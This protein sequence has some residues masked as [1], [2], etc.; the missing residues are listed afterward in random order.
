MNH[1]VRILVLFVCLSLGTYCA[2]INANDTSALRT[3]PIIG[4][5]ESIK[6]VEVPVLSIAPIT[7]AQ[8]SQR[9]QSAQIY[10]G[11]T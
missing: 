6:P 5:A 10:K 9:L 8:P 2:I 4:P 1:L 7:P 11:T 3:T